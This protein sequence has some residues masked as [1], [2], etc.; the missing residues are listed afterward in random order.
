MFCTAQSES[1]MNTNSAIG[2]SL[3][4][5]RTLS[6]AQSMSGTKMPTLTLLLLLEDI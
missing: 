4:I 5:I 1:L 3:E 6:V 2:I